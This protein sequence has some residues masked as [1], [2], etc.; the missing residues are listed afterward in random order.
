[1]IYVLTVILAGQ[2]YQIEIDP[3]TCRILQTQSIAAGA[4]YATCSEIRYVAA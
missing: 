3:L 2:F 4:T 1:M